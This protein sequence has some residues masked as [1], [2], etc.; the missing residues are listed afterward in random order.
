MKIDSS[1]TVGATCTKGESILEKCEYCDYTFQ[2]EQGGPLGHKLVEKANTRVP[3]TPTQNGSVIFE[4]IRCDYEE[5]RELVWSDSGSDD[6]DSGNTEQSKNATIKVSVTD[7]RNAV[8]NAKV[9]IYSGGNYITTKYTN[10]QGVTTFEVAKGKYNIVI[11]V[12]N[13]DKVEI[14]KDVQADCEIVGTVSIRG[15]GCACHR[16]NIWGAI[17]RFFHKIIKMLTGEFKCCSD[18]SHLYG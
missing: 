1:A 8:Q 2:H 12:T 18:P 3:A 4:C 14:T 6:D 13:A 5:E 11:T 15:C 17:F 9:D 10:A 7:G 16:D